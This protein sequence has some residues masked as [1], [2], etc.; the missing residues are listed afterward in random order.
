MFVSSLYI[1]LHL[2]P[3]I[4]LRTHLFFEG[5]PIAAITSQIVHEKAHNNE[6]EMGKRYKDYKLT[7]PPNERATQSQLRNFR[8]VKKRYLYYA[9]YRGVF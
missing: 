5:H 6:E 4:A 1:L 3:R 7:D 2:T 8:V 9:E